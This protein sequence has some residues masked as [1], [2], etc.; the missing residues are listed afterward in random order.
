MV[1]LCASRMVLS[2]AMELEWSLE[3]FG[4]RSAFFH[5]LYKY[6][7]PLFMREMARVVLW[8]KYGD[9]VGRLVKNQYGN[10]WGICYYIKGVL[11]YLYQNGAKCND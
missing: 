1:H 2:H 8:Y 4:V 6:E 11:V 7:D 10:P 5:G 3:H 9:T